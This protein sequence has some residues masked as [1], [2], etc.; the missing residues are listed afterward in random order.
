MK[1]RCNILFCYY[2]H[3]PSPHLS[4]SSSFFTIL[5]WLF[6]P[7]IGYNTC[8]LTTVFFLL[9]FY[10]TDSFEMTMKTKKERKK[11][12]SF[13]RN[14]LV[15][16][17]VVVLSYGA[18]SVRPRS[19]RLIGS[20]FG[21][22]WTSWTAEPTTESQWAEDFCFFFLFQKFHV[23]SFYDVKKRKKKMGDAIGLGGPGVAIATESTPIWINQSRRA[24]RAAPSVQRWVAGGWECGREKKGTK[25]GERRSKKYLCA[26][27]MNYVR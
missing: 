1:S 16:V 27:A 17:V 21:D 7:V 19:N 22:K 11:F 8:Q 12:I 23:A 3:E 2:L 15:V 24:K 20:R 4:S 10:I 26:S 13:I 9:L 25:K 5:L 6:S 18:F 14:Q